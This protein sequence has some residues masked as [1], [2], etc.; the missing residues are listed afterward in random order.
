[1]NSS[2]NSPHLYRLPRLTRRQTPANISTKQ[3]DRVIAMANADPRW[4]VTRDVVLILSATG[5]QSKEL[6]SLRMSDI[7]I[8]SNRMRVSSIGTRPSTRCLSL[9][10]QILH[11]IE[12][13]H[14]RCPESDF[15]LGDGARSLLT[16]VSRDLRLIASRIDADPFT[17]HALRR[18][19][20]LR[21]VSSGVDVATLAY[22]LGHSSLRSSTRYLP[23]SDQK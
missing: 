22:L 18:S 5:I 13:L 4:H 21:L 7:D 12:G 6:R 2:E 10:P 9:T 14:S 23:G 19:F 3:I 11:A 8:A 20:A 17:L 1:M 15:V 16:R